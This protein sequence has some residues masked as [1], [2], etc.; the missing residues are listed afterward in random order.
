MI[1]ADASLDLRISGLVEKQTSMMFVFNAKG[2]LAK[3]ITYGLKH[4]VKNQ[5]PEVMEVQ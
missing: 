5:Q 3:R 2:A 4:N 1:N